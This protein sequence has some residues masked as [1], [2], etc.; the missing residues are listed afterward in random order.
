MVD[1]STRENTLSKLFSPIKIGNLEVKNRLAMAPIGSVYSSFD[2]ALRREFK[3]FILAR[4]KGGVG[5]IMLADAGLGFTSI[6]VPV[7]PDLRRRMV[8]EAR[9]LVSAVHDHSVCI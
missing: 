6:E 8:K 1:I 9:D 4:A 7:D 2:G 3:D 5:M